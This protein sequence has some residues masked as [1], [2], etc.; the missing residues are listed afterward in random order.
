[1][2]CASKIQLSAT[3]PRRKKLALP[4]ILAKKTIS[5]KLRGKMMDR[6]VIF[7]FTVIRN[8]VR[9]GRNIHEYTPLPVTY[10]KKILGENDSRLCEGKG[11]EALNFK[12]RT[13]D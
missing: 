9:T 10:I 5:S 8:Q 1:M 11:L 13:N 12:Y 4:K 2:N 3:F 6:L 7:F